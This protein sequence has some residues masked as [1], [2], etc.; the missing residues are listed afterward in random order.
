MPF[1]LQVAAYLKPEHAENYLEELRKQAID[2]YVVK[3]HSNDK[4]W[5]QVRIAHFPDKAEA[6][7]YGSDLKSKGLIED[8]Y[9]AKD[10]IP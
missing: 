3:A 7:A 1:T 5:Y 10:Q 8:F 4:T 6:L 9:V 2:A